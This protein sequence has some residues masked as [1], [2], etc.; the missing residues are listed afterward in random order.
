MHYSYRR[1]QLLVGPAR[2]RQNSGVHMPN[3]QRPT[4]TRTPF[5]LTP[6]RTQHIRLTHPRYTLQANSL[7]CTCVRVNNVWLCVRRTEK[8]PEKSWEVHANLLAWQVT[9]PPLLRVLVQLRYVCWFNF[10]LHRL[11][12]NSLLWEPAVVFATV[13]HKDSHVDS[14]TTIATRRHIHFTHMF[15][16]WLIRVGDTTHCYVRHDS[17]TNTATRW[18][19]YMKHYAFMWDKTHFCETW[20]IHMWD[21]TTV[22]CQHQT[23]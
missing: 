20:L 18:H 16:T 19:I 8:R 10:S 23:C 6:Q 12:F 14:P 2:Q 1:W 9:P 22:T 4:R 7:A 21:I 5:Q 11:N 15:E 17:F 3:L 13:T